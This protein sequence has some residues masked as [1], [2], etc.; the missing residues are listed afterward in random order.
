MV[1]YIT[2]QYPYEP[3]SLD[4]VLCQ[5]LRNED[6]KRGYLT[7]LPSEKSDGFFIAKLV[8]KDN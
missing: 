4:D 7:L 3:V 2:S 8:R 5:D 1:S 6:T